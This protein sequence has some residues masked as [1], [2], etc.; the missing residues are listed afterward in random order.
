MSDMD[1]LKQAEEAYRKELEASLSSDGEVVVPDD[2]ANDTPED[3]STVPDDAASQSDKGTEKAE[4]KDVAYYQRLAEQKAKEAEQA[5]EKAKKR[6][7][8]LERGL[9][10]KIRKEK[11]LEVALQERERELQE[12]RKQVERKKV[13]ESSLID[14]EAFSEFNEE[15]A[16][17]A[18]HVKKL[19]E[20]Q[21][22]IN[23]ERAK[24]EAMR[25]KDEI[26]SQRKEL[27]VLIDKAK[28]ET[29]QTENA[30]H[31]AAVKALVPDADKIF[32]G[33][34]YY[35]AFKAWAEDSGIPLFQNVAG[36]PPSF[37]PKDVA[38][39]INRFKAE[40]GIKNAA[41]PK[42]GDMPVR[43]GH[44]TIPTDRVDNDYFTSDELDN[45]DFIDREMSK[46]VG[47]QAK[48]LAL[49]AKIEKSERKRR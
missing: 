31:F 17:L 29:A 45:L 43:T 33:K 27:Q 42:A 14:D 5:Q 15:F 34:G 44:E 41:S 36:A 21:A 7:T 11:E 40:C 12:L 18:P 6:D 24:A 30:K 9:H 20:K 37:D 26:E 23:S 4:V 1:E 38:Y 46:A 39:V 2:A 28:A 22:I 13:E 49:V 19:L 48:L 25:V 10:E 3:N 16:D 32:D 47:D 35:P 8:D